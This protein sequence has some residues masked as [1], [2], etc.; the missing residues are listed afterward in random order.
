[1]VSNMWIVKIDREKC[2]NC[3][4]CIEVC[5]EGS[6]ELIDK[7]PVYACTHTE[8]YPE[9]DLFLNVCPEDAISIYQDNAGSPK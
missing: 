7:K 3:L 8:H 4:E 5:Q 6:F 2:T 9:C 1:M